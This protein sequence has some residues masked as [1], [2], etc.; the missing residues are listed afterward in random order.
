MAHR[1]TYQCADPIPFW[2]TRADDV[3]CNRFAADDGSETIYSF[4]NDTDSDYTGPLC[5]ADGASCEIILGSGEADI[6]NGLLSGRLP[7]RTVVHVRVQ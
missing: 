6:Q 5:R 1:L 2:P 7:A 4:Y 3:Y